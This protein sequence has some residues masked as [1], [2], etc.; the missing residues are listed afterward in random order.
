MCSALMQTQMQTELYT[1][2]YM[3]SVF[4]YYTES[5]T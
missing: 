2:K 4:G 1:V 5:F 3:V